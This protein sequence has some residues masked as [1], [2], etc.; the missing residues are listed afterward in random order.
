MFIFY[1][2]FNHNQKLIHAW[3][4][5]ESSSSSPSNKKNKKALEFCQH[6]V[7]PCPQNVRTWS[8]R[9]TRFCFYEFCLKNL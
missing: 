9:D 3:Y 4:F 2:P 8:L 5:K 1:L 7:F 6:L